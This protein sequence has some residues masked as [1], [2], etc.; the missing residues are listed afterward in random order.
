[1]DDFF[2]WNEGG[3]S[4]A[5]GERE[6]YMAGARIVQAFEAPLDSPFTGLFEAGIF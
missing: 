1:M 5:A 3:G 4:L 2:T 6:M